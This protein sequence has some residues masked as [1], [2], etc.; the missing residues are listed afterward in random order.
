[1]VAPHP[2][3]SRKAGKNFTN[4][5]LNCK[6]PTLFR[7]SQTLFRVVIRRPIKLKSGDKR[8]NNSMNLL[9]VRPWAVADLLQSD[10]DRVSGR[11]TRPAGISGPEADWAPAMD[12]VEKQDRFEIRAD[13]PGVTAEDIDV[14]MDN[15]VLTLSG[16]RRAEPHSEDDGIKRS[17]RAFGRFSRRFTMPDTAEAEGIKARTSNGILEVSIPKLPEP[18]PRRIAVEAV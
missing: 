1:M 11:R 14:S 10:F 6:S 7:R 15:G 8:M 12:I 17:E 13:L 2:V 9:H 18:K 5:D 4:H 16:E 3:F